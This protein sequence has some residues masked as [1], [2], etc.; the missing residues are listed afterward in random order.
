[1][2]T[3]QKNP[4]AARPTQSRATDATQAT[5]KGEGSSYSPAPAY[6]AATTDH[7]IRR[8][9][10]GASVTQIQQELN[11]RGANLAADGKFGPE[12][13]AAVRRFQAQSGITVDGKVGPETIGALQRGATTESPEAAQARQRAASTVGNTGT[14]RAPTEADRAAT[15]DGAQRAGELQRQNPGTGP[16]G[17]ITTQP[18][19]DITARGTVGST[20]LPNGTT[21]QGPTGQVTVGPDGYLNG[22]GSLGRME[23]DGMFVE[24]GRVSVESGRGTVRAEA[25]AIEASTGDSNPVDVGARLGDI[26]AEATFRAMRDEGRIG[27]GY[28]AN[29]AEVNASAGEVSAARQD[30]YREQV[31]VSVGAP[32][33]GAF[34]SWNDRD[35]DGARNYRLDVDIPIPGTP[36]GVGASFES[37]SPVR[38]GIALVASLNPVTAPL[39]AGHRLGRMIGLW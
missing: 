18:N 3:I 36:F 15:P 24:A 25:T 37:E 32:S 38:D 39:A 11:A 21:V 28:R 12:T 27:A 9:H 30:D 8:G 19:G 16:S 20:E 22:H 33:G 4:A 13:D 31:R 29:I 17:S 23:R 1:M 5:A 7:P 35:G 2:S 26:G 10:E 34:V 6:N 14:P